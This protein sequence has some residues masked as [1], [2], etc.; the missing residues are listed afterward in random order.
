MKID[1]RADM[2][3]EST[4]QIAQ[5]YMAGQSPHCATSSL[6]DDEMILI[7]YYVFEKKKKNLFVPLGFLTWQIVFTFLRCHINILYGQQLLLAVSRDMDS[8]L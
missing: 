4:D 7:V 5:M 1:F 3:I 6:G 2:D 8:Y